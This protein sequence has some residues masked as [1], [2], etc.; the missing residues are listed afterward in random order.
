[1]KLLLTALVVTMALVSTTGCGSSENTVIE[2][3]DYQMTEQEESNR[4][5][6]K[7][8]LASQQQ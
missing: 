6:E 3:Q 7:A 4:E 1:M 5:R 2:P 8:A